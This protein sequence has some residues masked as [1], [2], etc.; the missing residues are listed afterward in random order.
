MGNK[1]CKPSEWDDWEDCPLKCWDGKK[2]ETQKRTRPKVCKE[3]KPEDRKAKESRECPVNRSKI[4][5]VIDCAPSGDWEEWTKC[6]AE[7]GKEGKQ[8]R[9]RDVKKAVNGGKDCKDKDRQETKTCKASEC[10]KDCQLGPPS[11][12]TDC[13]KKCGAGG[14]KKR[15]RMIIQEPFGKGAKT[16][17]AV[18]TEKWICDINQQKDGVCL[19]Q[20]EDCKDDPSCNEAGGKGAVNGTAVIAPPTAADRAAMLRKMGH[21][22]GAFDHQLS[23][24][25][26]CLIL[27]L[28]FLRR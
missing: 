16:C 23:P 24:I 9:K 8:T 10:T 14:K 6:D 1:G 4:T 17:L 3:G 26:I 15:Q 5:C 19:S 2:T 11:K 20:E 13:P 28:F 21:H 18:D 27:L 12:W 22:G 7:C 25:V